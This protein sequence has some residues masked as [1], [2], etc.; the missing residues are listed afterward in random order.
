MRQEH[1]FMKLIVSITIEGRPYLGAAI[2]T[3]CFQL[4]FVAVK[5]SE[6]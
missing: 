4:A 5:L 3:I 2:G 1:Y 6:W